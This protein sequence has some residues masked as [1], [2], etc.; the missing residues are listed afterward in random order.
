MRQWPIREYIAMSGGWY[1]ERMQPWI[2]IGKLPVT[3]DSTFTVWI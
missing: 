1:T 2:S 3:C